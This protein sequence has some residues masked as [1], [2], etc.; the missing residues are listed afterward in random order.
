M[1]Q[2]WLNSLPANSR[3]C[4]LLMIYANSLDPNQAQQNVRPDLDPRCLTLCYSEGIYSGGKKFENY[5][6]TTKIG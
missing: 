5:L 4:H 6:Q 3:F 2:L 1:K